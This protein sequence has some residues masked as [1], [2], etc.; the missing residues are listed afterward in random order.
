ME[1]QLRKSCT[2]G[3]ARKGCA[4]ASAL[5]VFTWGQGATFTQLKRFTVSEPCLHLQS[6]LMTEASMSVIDFPPYTMAKC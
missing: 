2:E 4:K 5:L 1:C 6:V 3:Q